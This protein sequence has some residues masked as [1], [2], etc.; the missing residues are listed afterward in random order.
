MLA[1]VSA[2]PEEIAGVLQTSQ[3]VSGA[4]KDFHLVGVAQVMLF[5]DEGPIAIEKNS[6]P[7][8]PRLR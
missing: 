2:M 7:V 8:H 6:A 1:I 5:G 3:S 4:G